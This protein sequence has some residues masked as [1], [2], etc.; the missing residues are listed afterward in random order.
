MTTPDDNDPTARRARAVFEAASAGL[1]P[2]TAN[3]LRLAR[4]DA[5]AGPPARRFALAPLAGAVA[6]ALVALWLWPRAHAP[7]PAPLATTPPAPAVAPAV[8]P[9]PSAVVAPIPEP[10]S[11]AALPE[12]PAVV[13]DPL[14]DALADDEF[15]LVDNEEDAEL[16]A[17]LADAPVA[18]DDEGAL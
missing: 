11:V 5:L 14:D 18:P 3:R 7:A 2:A 12:R 13:P 15:D 8:P 9:A 17:W 6:L 10:P 4:R 16:Y 1:D